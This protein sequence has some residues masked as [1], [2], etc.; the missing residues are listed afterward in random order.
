MYVEEEIYTYIFGTSVLFSMFFL[1][2]VRYIIA[3][4]VLESW[5]IRLEKDSSQI[6]QTQLKIGYRNQI[7]ACIEIS[8]RCTQHKPEDRLST[9]DI[10]RALEKTEAE[11]QSVARPTPNVGRVCTC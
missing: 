10:L 5:A 2:I 9:Q 1:V 6:R 3:S 8:Q 4:Q 11:V 7:K